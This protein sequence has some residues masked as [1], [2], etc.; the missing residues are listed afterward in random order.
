MVD[1][2]LSGPLSPRL[3]PDPRHARRA[4]LRLA[5]G[6]ADERDGSD[7]LDDRP[8]LR[9]R[10]REA[11]VEQTPLETDDGSFR[12]TERRRAAVELVLTA[13][14]MAGLG[15]AIHV[16]LAHGAKDVDAR[17]RRQVYAVCASLTA[18]GA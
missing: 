7:G 13:F 15:P 1:G 16:F 18:G 8:P 11:R 6:H 9:D 3:H 10:L 4:R 2:E 5:M 14:V 12:E 17:Q